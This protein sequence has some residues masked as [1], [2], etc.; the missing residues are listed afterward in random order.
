MQS[1][2]KTNHRVLSAASEGVQRGLAAADIGTGKEGGT[3]L[4]SHAS[5]GAW[6]KQYKHLGLQDP[7]AKTPLP[8]TRAVFCV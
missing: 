1:S 8:A 7:G 6:K 3:A 5:P 4:S 2:K